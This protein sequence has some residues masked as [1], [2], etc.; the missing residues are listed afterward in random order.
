[1]KDLNL[2]PLREDEH[3]RFFY[4]AGSLPEHDSWGKKGRYLRGD[5]EEFKELLDYIE[6]FDPKCFLVADEFCGIEL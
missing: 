3:K 5:N 2:G 4:F 6:S 1:M